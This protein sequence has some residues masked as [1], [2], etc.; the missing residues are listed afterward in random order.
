M[1]AAERLDVA[2]A[3]IAKARATP[4]PAERT[5]FA[6]GAA[7]QISAFLLSNG[8][9]PATAKQK[10][11]RPRR[12]PALGLTEAPRHGRRLTAAWNAYRSHR[13]PHPTGQVIDLTL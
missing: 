2:E 9:G 8:E 4:F 11:S 3:L 7:E 13:H 1:G 5:A 6:A 12:K 10:P